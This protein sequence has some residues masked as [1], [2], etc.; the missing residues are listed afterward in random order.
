MREEIQLSM[1]VER[2][3]VLA[4]VIASVSRAV[5]ECPFE[6]AKVRMQTN[7]KWKLKDVYTGFTPLLARTTGLMTLYF[8]IID[9]L[10]RHTNMFNSI[11]GIKYIFSSLFSFYIHIYIH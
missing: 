2:R 11:P 7:Q 10:R 8:V 9:S 4:G 5:V 6:Y 3:T 1:G